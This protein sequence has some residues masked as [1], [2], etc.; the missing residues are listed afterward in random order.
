MVNLMSTRNVTLWQDRNGRNVA[1]IVTVSG[2]VTYTTNSYASAKTAYD[3]A[4][5]GINVS[6]FE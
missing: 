3:F 6:E 2:R 4:V 1:Y 5:D